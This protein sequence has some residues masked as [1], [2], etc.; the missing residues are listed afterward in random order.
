M[1]SVLSSKNL[2]HIYYKLYSQNQGNKMGT[3]R[4]EFVCPHFLFH[5]DLL[6]NTDYSEV[7]IYPST[8]KQVSFH[9]FQGFV[10]SKPVTTNIFY[11]RI[12]NSW[13][14]FSFSFFLIGYLL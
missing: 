13:Y 11:K 1:V 3:T 14:L 10:P 6:D 5:A 12:L 4:I 7:W 2:R 8:S 9:V